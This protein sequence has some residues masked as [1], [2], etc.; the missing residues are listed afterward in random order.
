MY[1]F[2]EDE[3]VWAFSNDR[4]TIYFPFMDEET[5]TMVISKDSFCGNHSDDLLAQYYHNTTECEYYY[6]YIRPY[7]DGNV[8]VEDP[9]EMIARID[10]S[11]SK[12][13]MWLGNLQGATMKAGE[14]TITNKESNP[15]EFAI[16]VDGGERKI[17]TNATR[18][19][20]EDNSG[21]VDY[22]YVQDGIFY[23][24]LTEGE[25][26][27]SRDIFTFTKILNSTILQ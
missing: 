1:Y 5:N 4:N 2:S 19:T 8:T 17:T 11:N 22:M 6:T 23:G 15:N 14:W 7:S 13:A 27:K 16:T 12:V 10:Y 24:A 9:Y 25:A 26:K 18:I 20:V 3:A 21:R